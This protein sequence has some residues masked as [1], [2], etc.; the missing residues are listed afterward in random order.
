MLLAGA[1]IGCFIFVADLSSMI[2]PPVRPAHAEP[3]LGYNYLVK[4]KYGSIFGTYFEYWTLTYGV[5]L[6]LLG[7]FGALALFSLSDVPQ[8]SR[9]FRGQIVITACAA[10]AIYHTIWRLS[11]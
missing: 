11:Q 9:T 10:G 2:S 3:A 7:G 8:K 4:A 5:F 6:A 1:L